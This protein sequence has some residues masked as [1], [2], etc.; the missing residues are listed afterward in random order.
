MVNCEMTCALSYPL[1]QLIK[2]IIVEFKIKMNLRINIYNII[3]VKFHKSRIRFHD[4][5]CLYF[6]LQIFIVLTF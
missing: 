1:N 6:T 2:F 3:L 5:R 4:G